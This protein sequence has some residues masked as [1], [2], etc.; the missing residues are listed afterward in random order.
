MR[1]K[2]PPG[3]YR[4]IADWGLYAYGSPGDHKRTRAG[5]THTEEEYTEWEDQRWCS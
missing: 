5:S 3:G 1:R 4:G 2:N